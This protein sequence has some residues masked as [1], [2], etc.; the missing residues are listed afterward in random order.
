M[1]LEM[2]GLNHTIFDTQTRGRA[3]IGPDRMSDIA[4]QV[5]ENENVEGVVILS[6]CNRVEF[7][8]SP[9]LHTP[10]AELRALFAQICHLSDE[11]SYEPYILRDAEVTHHLFRV[12]S[13]L[14]SQLLGEV[15]ILTQVKQAY[16][17]ALELA[18]TNSVLNRLFL[19]AIEC[20]KLVRTR[21]GISQGAVSVAF[22]AVDLAERVFGKLSDR[23]V[24]LI[25]AGET[26]QLAAKYIADSGATHWRISNRTSE[27][28]QMLA[29]LYHGQAVSFPPS[30]ADLAW[31]DLVVSATSSPEP[32]ITAAQANGAITHRKNPALFLDLAVPRD[33]DPD[34]QNADNVYV[35][36]VDDF[37]E[38]VETNL[39]A[40]ERE[41]LRAG[42]LVEKEVEEFV[43]WYRENRI[44]PT[45]QQLQMVL[46]AIRM[47]EVEHNVHRFTEQDREQVEKFSRSMMKKVTGLIVANMKRASLDKNDLSLA[48]AI[49]MSF[50]R[51]DE[52][53]VNDVLEKLD[54]EL[55]H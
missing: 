36:C 22:A 55:S 45:I 33:I 49:T 9:N 27:R 19:Q 42:K 40:R 44:A 11:E 3:A 48:R 34:L 13:G 29:E 1:K 17:A 18:C 43:V 38:M 47:S 46:E 12:A 25:G 32:V 5:L 2:I 10:E 31:A 6:T 8:L 52:S 7:Y 30:Q 21:T 39:R 23:N 50:A 35:Y 14:D 15:Q 37:R 26:I 20:G 51:E 28:A 53:A 41:A 4:N 54:H 24:L 16:H